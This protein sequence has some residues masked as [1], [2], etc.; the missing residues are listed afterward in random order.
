MSQHNAQKKSDN[1]YQTFFM[2]FYQTKTTQF[3]YPAILTSLHNN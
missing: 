2:F 1:N 3:I